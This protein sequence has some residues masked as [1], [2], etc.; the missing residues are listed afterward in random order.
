V[1]EFAAVTTR[2]VVRRGIARVGALL[3]TEDSSFVVRAKGRRA[4]G[5][6][7]F[8]HSIPFFAEQKQREF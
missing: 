4:D 2:K 8:L 3:R 1:K 6:R 5:A 7:F